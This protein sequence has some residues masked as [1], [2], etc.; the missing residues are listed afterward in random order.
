MNNTNNTEKLSNVNWFKEDVESYMSF[1]IASYID[2]YWL[3]ILVPIGLTGNTL[4]FLVMMK[5][6]NRKM[7]TCIYMAAIS[8]N[9]N[10]MMVLALYTWLVIT[11]K[12]HKVHPME[13]KFIA[14]MVFVAMQNSTFLVL[15]MTLDKFTAIKWPHKAATYST[16]TRAK[17]TVIGVVVCVLVYNIPHIFST[18]MVGDVCLGYAIGGT[19]TKFYSWLSFILNAAVPFLLLIYMNYVI[20]QKVR[21]SHKMFRG[22]NPGRGQGEGEQAGQSTAVR[23]QNKMKNTENQLTIMLLLVTTLFLVLMIPTYIR[24]VYTSFVTRDTPAK[25]ASLMLFYHISHKLYN[26]NNGI[27]FFLYCISGQ[28][29]RNDLKE[30][31]S[32]D[33]RAG[34]CNRT[35][36]NTD[37]TMIS[38]LSQSSLVK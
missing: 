16:A 34:Q 36:Q 27:N 19:I 24:F 29:F 33:R 21:S 38:T 11:L 14:F 31:L 26:T 6:N 7:S 10:L 2:L 1:K 5:P 35:G 17:M 32:C 28:K 37:E 23:R 4:S 22:N 20:V 8:L 12:I 25:Y 30:L 15:V 9:D 13:C 18:K 3:P